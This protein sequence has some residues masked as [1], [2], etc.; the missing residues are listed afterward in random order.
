MPRAAEGTL[1]SAGGG[2]P[3]LFEF[4]EQTLHVAFEPTPLRV[5][6]LTLT[7]GVPSRWRIY[8]ITGECQ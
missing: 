5:V 2:V 6:R 8:E 7:A 4:S 1:V 3:A